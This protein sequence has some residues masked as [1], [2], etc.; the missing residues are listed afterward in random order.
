MINQQFLT[1]TRSQTKQMQE[2]TVNKRKQ[3][4][5]VSNRTLNRFPS[6]S[7][8]HLCSSANLFLVLIHNDVEA[9]FFIEHA[10]LEAAGGRTDF[11]T[12]VE[13]VVL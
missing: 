3:T 7:F 13:N 4:R 10:N 12:D 6:M 2:S 1:V 11:G 9:I 5:M 8:S